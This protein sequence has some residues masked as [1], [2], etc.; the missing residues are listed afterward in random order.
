M[1]AARLPALVFAVAM[2]AYGLLFLAAER[3]RAVGALIV[4][5]AAAVALAARFGLLARVRAS[6]A[7][8]E[9]TFD[10]TA[11][12]GV[13]VVA[14]WFHE[15]HFVLLMMTTALLL[16]TAALGLTVQFG[17]AGVVNF[18]GAAF[19]GIGCYTAAVLTKYT[20]VPPLL[21]LPLGGAAAALIG[22]ILIFPVL[23]TRGHYAALVTIAFGVLFKTFIEVNDVLG[24]PQGM[25]V[26]PFALAGHSFNDPIRIGG[27]E[28]SFYFAYVLA[29][30]ALLVL[31]F[32]LVRRLERSWIGLSLD[33]IRLDEVASA[34]YGLD[35]ARWKVFAFTL[36]NFLAGCAGAL[37]GH[38][39]G[40]IAPNNFTFGDSLVLVSIILLGGIGNPWGVVAAAAFVVI[41]PE[42]FQVIQE[43]RFALY[44]SLVILVLLFR[45][46][47]LLPRALR[48]YFPGRRH[49]TA[50]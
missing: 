14:L 21:I 2:T 4:A 31:A 32:A 16:M 26:G 37:Y 50:P 47:G 20:P 25:S 34:C 17:Y 7:A 24:G 13:L 15:E 33:A 46:V 38:V 22:S 27:F 8:N 18:A 19:L 5:G 35:I 29:A 41:L 40:F 3:E 12:A 49:E 44:A 11:I 23:R 48:D 42:K 1:A 6:I 30:L 39:L 45:P 43:Y 9:G 28:A 10:A 36:G